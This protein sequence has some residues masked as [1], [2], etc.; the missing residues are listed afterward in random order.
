M[1]YIGNKIK[2]GNF[3]NINKFGIS[4]TSEMKVRYVKY[5]VK[6]QNLKYDR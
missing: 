4:R 3:R 5:I 6:D 2:N 1:F